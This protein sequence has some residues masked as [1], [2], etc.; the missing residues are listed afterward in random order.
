[1]A[2]GRLSKKAKRLTGL[3]DYLSKKVEEVEKERNYD[4]TYSHKVHLVNLKKQ[5]LVAKDRLKNE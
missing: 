5:K 1:M 4:R 2:T 3:H